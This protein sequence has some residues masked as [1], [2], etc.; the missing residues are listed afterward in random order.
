MTLSRLRVAPPHPEP[1]LHPQ[2]SPMLLLPPP[3]VP[4]L[5]PRAIPPSLPQHRPADTLL[6]HLTLVRDPSVDQTLILLRCHRS[7]RYAR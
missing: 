5:A 1:P 6:I 2:R 4:R 7:G 3:L